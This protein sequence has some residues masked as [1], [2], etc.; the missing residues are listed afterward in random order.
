MEQILML[1]ALPFD[2]QYPA[3]CIDER[4]CFLIGDGAESLSLQTGV[5]RLAGGN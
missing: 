4:P 5:L 3:I 1:Y 2:P